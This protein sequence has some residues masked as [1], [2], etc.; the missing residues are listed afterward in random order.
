VLGAHHDACADFSDV[1][2]GLFAGHLKAK[3]GSRDRNYFLPVGGVTNYDLA[4]HVVEVNISL[5]TGRKKVV[6]RAATRQNRRQPSYSFPGYPADSL[7]V[8][9]EL[10]SVYLEVSLFVVLHHLRVVCHKFSGVFAQVNVRTENQ[11]ETAGFLSKF[12]LETH[13]LAP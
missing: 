6:K 3:H 4:V 12:E 7:F 10:T 13:K 1:L 11:A 9:L 8:L 2:H 5:K